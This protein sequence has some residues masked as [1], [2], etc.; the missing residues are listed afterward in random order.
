MKKSLMITVTGL[1]V[2]LTAVFALT[3]YVYD[4]SVYQ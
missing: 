2:M 3:A 4:G 1:C